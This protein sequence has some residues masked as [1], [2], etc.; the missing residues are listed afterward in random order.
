MSAR[1]VIGCQRCQGSPVNVAAHFFCV[2]WPFLAGGS[3]RFELALCGECL[4]KDLQRP[5]PKRG[6]RRSARRSAGFVWHGAWVRVEHRT[7]T[8]PR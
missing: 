3:V 8:T 6:A 4:L 2:E 1:G 7:P 5:K